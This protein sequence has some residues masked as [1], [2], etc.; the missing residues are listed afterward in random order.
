M[1]PPRWV[2]LKTARKPERGRDFDI[3]S[4]KLLKFWAQ[5]Y[6]IGCPTIIIGYRDRE[7]FLYELEELQ[8]QKIP[9]MVNRQYQFKW[10][11]N[12]CLAAAAAVLEFLTDNI[13]GGGVWRISRSK[14]E[15]RIRLSKE[16]QYGSGT[17]NIISSSFKAWR[18]SAECAQ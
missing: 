5:S 4:K 7:G 18:E 17:G 2:E 11:A 3:H 16:E 9:T 12:A 15:Q 14:G 1:D 8:T 6:L 13:K 10:D